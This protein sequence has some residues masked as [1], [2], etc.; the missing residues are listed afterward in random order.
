ME[1]D[2]RLAKRRPDLAAEWHPTKNG[3]LTLDLVTP[4]SSRKVWWIC[5]KGHEWQA[6]IYSRATLGTGCPICSSELKTS[7]P[8]QAI[9]YYMKKATPA[10]SRNTEFGKEIDVYL[11]ELRVGIEYNGAYYHHGHEKKDAAK[12]AF[13]AEKNIR[14]ITVKEGDGN[15]VDGD[16]IEYIYS[17]KKD[18]LNWAISALFQLLDLPASAIDTLAAAAEIYEQYIQLEKENSL[19]EKFPK[20]AAQWHPIKNGKLTPDQFPCGSQKK[21]WWLGLCGHEW[22]TDIVGRT[23]GTGCPICAGKQILPGFNDLATTHP[24]LAAQWHPTKNGELTPQMVVAGRNKKVWWQCAMGHEWEARVNNRS[25][26]GRG[27]PVCAGK[28][29]LEGFNDLATT[30]PDLAAEWHPTKNG[31]LTP[32]MVT[33]MSGVKVW[34]RGSCG[35]EWQK[36]I[37]KRSLRYGCPICAGKQVLPGFNDLATT[38]PDLAAEWHPIKNGEL[39]PEMVTDRSGKKVWWLGTCGHEWRTMVA[40]RSNG[41]GCPVCGH[42]KTWETRR[43]NNE[44]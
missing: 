11:P 28:Q 37:A 9:L 15:R 24:E 17:S 2:N 12:V 36:M 31:E 38:N 22:Q 19:A 18:S 43:K 1:Y 34:W 39:L 5:A 30:N 41:T 33:A 32:Q 13:F 20:L 35:H 25:Q 16:V 40:H 27:C 23:Q 21:V 10:E 42:K 3:E 44:T 4:G 14:I 6:Q 29:V 8:E 26:L 7:F